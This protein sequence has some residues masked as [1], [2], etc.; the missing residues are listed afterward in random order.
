[1]RGRISD[2]AEWAAAQRPYREQNQNRRAMVHRPLFAGIID[3]ELLSGRC[4]LFTGD[5]RICTARD[6]P[7]VVSDWHFTFTSRSQSG[8]M[9]NG[10]GWSSTLDIYQLQFV[11][12]H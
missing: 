7:G 10:N 1:L 4:Q 3:A 9:E 8:G 5:F 11:N 2:N 6:D 12:R